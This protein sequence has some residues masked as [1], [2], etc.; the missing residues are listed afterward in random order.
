MPFPALS[1][2]SSQRAFSVWGSANSSPLTKSLANQ[3]ANLSH[4]AFDSTFIF[5]A[6]SLLRLSISSRFISRNDLNAD[7]MSALFSWS[8]G[9]SSIESRRVVDHSE[10]RVNT[11]FENDFERES[12]NAAVCASR[13]FLRAAF[14]SSYSLSKKSSMISSR[15]LLDVESV[16]NDVFKDSPACS[17]FSS[18]T[19]L[20]ECPSI[21]PFSASCCI[22]ATTA[23]LALSQTSSFSWSSFALFHA[24]YASNALRL[25][26]FPGKASNPASFAIPWEI[27]TTHVASEGTF[28]S[29]NIFRKASI[30]SV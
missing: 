5:S 22:P 13:A 8:N 23:L 3:S 21:S 16:A 27:A 17:N 28:R 4:N 10:S 29:S 20:R 19:F 30:S 25:R 15:F 6:S 12:A 24:K 11:P 1:G 9:P 18:T 14:C 26:F 2:C 7:S